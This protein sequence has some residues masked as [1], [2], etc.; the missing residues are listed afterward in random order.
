MPTLLGV[1]NLFGWRNLG[2]SEPRASA[3]FKSSTVVGIDFPPTASCHGMTVASNGVRLKTALHFADFVCLRK[4]LLIDSR[5]EEPHGVTSLSTFTAKN[6]DLN[7][8][9]ILDN[10]ELPHAIRELIANAIDESILTKSASPKVIKDESGWWTIR[11]FGRGL[12]YQDLIQSEN[13]E[14]MKSPAVIGKFGIGLKD[15]LA[16]FDRKGVKVEIKSKFG[17]I[18]LG[19]VSKH[20]FDDLVTLHASVSPPSMTHLEGTICRLFG[21]SDADVKTASDMFL[22]FSNSQPIETTSYG[23]V[24]ARSSSAGIIYI[25]GMK[26]AEEENFLFSYNIT[27]LNAAIKKSLNRERQNLGRT[28]YS[29]RIRAIL[30]ECKSDAVAQA[31]AADLQTHSHGRAH[32]ELGWLDVQQH[33]VRILNATKRVLFVNPQDLIDKPDLID[34]ATRG[35]YAIITVPTALS[36][37]IR[38]TKD[39]TGT[40]ITEINEFVKQ[41]NASFQFEW[42]S[43]SELTP[44]EHIVWNCHSRLLDFIGGRPSSVRDIRISRTMCVDPLSCTDALGLWD[45]SNGWVIIRRDQLR[46]ERDFAGTFLHELI[47]AKFGVGDVNRDFELRL[48]DLIGRLAASFL[49]MESRR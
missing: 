1:T 12:R 18:G 23:S 21:V 16:T 45:P 31:L 7:I 34:D 4:P 20:S 24:H 48:T 22:C 28:A 32:D 25:N 49:E 37:K 38:G 30:L 2:S 33:A 42:I 3:T 13:P 26:V 46:S 15:A 47:H 35:G 14:K 39:V 29:D 36:D 8:D 19:R 10:W 5:G 43:P 44:S 41:Q 9:K 6:F 27:A 17:D 40:P 11:D